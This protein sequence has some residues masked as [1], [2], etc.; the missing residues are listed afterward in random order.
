MNLEQLATLPLSNRIQ[1]ME[2]L[3]ASMDNPAHTA[4]PS[5]HADVLHERRSEIDNGH[6]SDWDTAKA[7]LQSK[8]TLH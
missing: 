8:Y 6:Y 2:I 7:R 5:W 1:A 4:S 3:W